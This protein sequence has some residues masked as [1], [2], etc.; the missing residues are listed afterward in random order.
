LQ[1]PEQQCASF[2][3]RAR[4]RRQEVVVQPLVL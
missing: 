2:E 1:S 4:Q 3:Q